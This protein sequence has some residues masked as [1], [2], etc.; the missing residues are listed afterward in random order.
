[1]P[2][3]QNHGLSHVP[4]KPG[5]P[6]G[7]VYFGTIY[8]DWQPSANHPHRAMLL[9]GPIGGRHSSRRFGHAL[10]HQ[11]AHSMRYR[12]IFHKKGGFRLPYG[13]SC[14]EMVPV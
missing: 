14:N 4:R 11:A 13:I 3:G 10:L 5:T 7:D 12:R 6:T 1:M 9:A 8:A 2:A